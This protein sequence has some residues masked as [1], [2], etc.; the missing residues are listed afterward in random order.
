MSARH[1][2]QKND[3][4]QGLEGGDFSSVTM[5]KARSEA[6]KNTTRP[7]LAGKRSRFD[8]VSSGRR[9]C[10][11]GQSPKSYYNLIFN[12]SQR[13]LDWACQRSNTRII[14]KIIKRINKKERFSINDFKKE[15]STFDFCSNYTIL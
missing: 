11:L 7:L 13:V 5:P 6:K 4:L 12:Y 3:C 15:G 1:C 8:G 9:G 2:Q 10:G 14:K